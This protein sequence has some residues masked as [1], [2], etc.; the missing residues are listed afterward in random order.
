M[1]SYAYGKENEHRY[2]TRLKALEVLN[3][4]GKMKP[5]CLVK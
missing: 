4:N 3:Q 5:P 1:L 2:T